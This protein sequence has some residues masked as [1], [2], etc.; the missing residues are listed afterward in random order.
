M[1]YKVALVVG[2]GL[3]FH[4]AT[5]N[6]IEMEKKDGAVLVHQATTAEIEDL[7]KQYGYDNYSPEM[8]KFPRIFVDTM[9]S[10]WDQ[11][12]DSDDKHRTFI[13]MLLPLVL[14]VNE[15]I[16]AERAAIEAIAA[17]Y[18]RMEKLSADELQ[19]LEDKAK[20]YDV[21]THLKGDNRPGYLL[22]HLLDKIDVVPPSIMVA[23]AGIYSAWGTNRLAMQGND[24]YR[25]EIWYDN[26]GM[27]PQDDPNGGYRY[28]IYD[29]ITECIADR[30]LKINSHINYDYIRESRRVGRAM[31]YP[32]YSP[33]LAAQMLHDSNLH[34]VS[35]LIDYTFSFYGLQRTD[36]EPE[37]VDVE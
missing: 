1:N 18:N 14:R 4:V 28:K 8:S 11:T 10:D 34:N 7:F 31:G 17:K 22:S 20:K 19:L 27:Q 13:R 25:E 32:P 5:A 30:A 26:K 21:F 37:L 36:F 23:T 2:L 15:Q 12:E 16:L 3:F 33:Q 24:F 9:P 6:A 35:G 29:N